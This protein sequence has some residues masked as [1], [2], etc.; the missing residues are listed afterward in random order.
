MIKNWSCPV[1]LLW[2]RNAGAKADKTGVRNFSRTA[3][4]LSLTVFVLTAG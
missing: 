2:G 4:A 3:S 1:P